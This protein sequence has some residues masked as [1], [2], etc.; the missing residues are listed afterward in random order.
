MKPIF[1]FY[2]GINSHEDQS[3]ILGQLY[4]DLNVST[5]C[6]CTCS[7][8]SSK[9]Y[10][11]SWPWPNWAV[12]GPVTY[13]SQNLQCPGSPV[14]QMVEWSSLQ[15]SHMQHWNYTS[16]QTQNNDGQNLHPALQ[17]F[18][19]WFVHIKSLRNPRMGSTFSNLYYTVAASNL[20]LTVIHHVIPLNTTAAL[21]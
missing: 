16:P 13:E 7:A 12:E 18:H 3:L 1:C 10:V 4:V 9:I 8:C 21:L 15:F 19:L 17:I 5:C 20:K 2:I 6:M 11:A 14:D